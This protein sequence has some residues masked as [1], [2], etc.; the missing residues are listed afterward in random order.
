VRFDP[1]R[2]APEGTA[3]LGSIPGPTGPTGPPR[4][5]FGTPYAATPEPPLADPQPRTPLVKEKEDPFRPTPPL[6]VPPLPDPEKKQPDPEVKRKPPARPESVD[7]PGFIQV[8]PQIA[9]GLQPYPPDGDAWLANQGYRTVIHLREP[10]TNDQAAR[11][12]FEKRGLRYVSIEVTP[13]TV[14]RITLERL[15]RILADEKNRPVYIYDR[16]GYLVGGLWYLRLRLIDGVD[17][18]KAL[19]E[20]RR[21]GLNPEQNANHRAMWNAVR[22]LA[23]P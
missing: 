6:V 17:A 3:P 10:D 20:A 22:Q 1:W 19:E 21:L 15:Q 5:Q 13:Q 11:R 12:Q 23:E 4:I 8:E 18:T 7:I 9:V 2:P 16:D 14:D